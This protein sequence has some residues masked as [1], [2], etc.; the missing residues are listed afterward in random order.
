MSKHLAVMSLIYAKKGSHVIRGRF[1]QHFTR[2]FYM[3]R[4]QKR[5]KDWWLHCIFELLG[6]VWVKAAHKMLVKSTPGLN[7]INV[8]LTAFTL[9]DPKSIK[10]TVKLSIF[11]TLLGS[12]SVKAVRRTLMKLSPGANPAKLYYFVEAYFFAINSKCHL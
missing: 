6:S 1:H 8:L 10:K 4:S 7:F 5:N 3:Q 12:T 9:P 11:F 2:S